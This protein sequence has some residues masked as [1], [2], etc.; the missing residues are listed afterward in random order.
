MLFAF[1]VMLLFFPIVTPFF[2]GFNTPSV[3][4]IL[5]HIRA[6]APNNK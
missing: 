4:G 1:T 3:F 5:L 6:V 2:I